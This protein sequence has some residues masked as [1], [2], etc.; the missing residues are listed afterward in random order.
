MLSF[1]IKMQEIR[2]IPF[3]ILII[4]PKFDGDQKL[5]NLFLRKSEYVIGAFR[6]EPPNVA[7]DIYI[8][9][10][11][12]G[13]LRGGVSHLISERQDIN[14]WT[15]LKTIRLLDKFRGN[16]NQFNKFMRHL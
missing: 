9:H 7:Q 11:I 14:N 13:R 5:L 15:E 3:D 8:F 16:S 6:S 2:T 10:A 1:K 12:T 4:V